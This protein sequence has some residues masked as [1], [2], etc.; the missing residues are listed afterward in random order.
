MILVLVGT[1]APPTSME[2]MN[3]NIATITPNTVVTQPNTQTLTCVNGWYFS[4]STT[5]KSFTCIGLE[6]Y[7]PSL[8]YCTGEVQNN[9]RYH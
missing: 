5:S 9:L 1:C 2:L 4:D 3:G 6:T 8:E 7:D